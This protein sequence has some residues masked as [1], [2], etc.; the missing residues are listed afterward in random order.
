MDELCVET[1]VLPAHWAS[2]LINGDGSG[3]TEE[4]LKQI[5]AFCA[6]VGVSRNA[7][8][9][10]DD[11]H[12]SRSHDALREMPLASSVATFT[13]LLPYVPFLIRRRYFADGK[14]WELFAVF[15]TIAADSSSYANMQGYAENGDFFSCSAEYLHSSRKIRGHDPQAVAAFEKEVRRVWELDE[16]FPCRLY[17]YERIQPRHHDERRTGW[18]AGRGE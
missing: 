17:R 15:P 9:V 8:S 7:A 18:K 1:Y 2:V 12:F 13:F 10:D 11:E 6:R 5:E 14:Q 16:S 3:T 4:E